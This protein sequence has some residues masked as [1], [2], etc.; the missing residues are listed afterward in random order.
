MRAIIAGGRGFIGHNL[1]QRLLGQGWKVHVIDNL[2]TGSNPKQAGATYDEEN[3]VNVEFMKHRVAEFKPNVIFHE[4]AIPRVSY[5]VKNP[6][7]TTVDNVLGTVS[8]LESVRVYTANCKIIVAS[9]SSVYGDADELPT[10]ETCIPNPC[11][12]YALQKL[13]LEGW[14]HMYANLYGLDICCLRYFNCYDEETD[15]LTY[16][17]FKRFKDITFE[18]KIATLNPVNRNIEYYKPIDIQKHNY[19][20]D[21]VHFEG[22]KIDLFVTPEHQILTTDRDGDTLLFRSAKEL[23]DS[24]EYKS[25]FAQN[26][27]WRG[28]EILNEII[29]EVRNE[30]ENSRLRPENAKKEI[31]MMKWVK[32]LGWFLSEGSAFSGKSSSYGKE[33]KY[34]RITITQKDEKTI[35]EIHKLVSEIGFNSN[36]V[37]HT[38]DCYE[39]Q[40]HSKQLFKHLKIF[41]HNKHIPRHILNLPI[42]YLVLL[43]ETLMRG[44]GTKSKPI[45]TTKY[46]S[47]ASDFQELLLKLGWY[48]RCRK[49]YSERFDCHVYRIY[50]HQRS[51][52][53]FGS[54]GKGIYAS[55]K[56]Y[57]GKVYDVT[58]PNHIIYVRR[59][60]FCC[61][62]GNCFGKH[63]LFGGPYS[64][65]LSAWLYSLFVD[66]SVRPF[67][68]GD[69]TQTRDFCCVDNVVSA[70]LL[71][72]QSSIKFKGHVFNIAQG[73]SHSLIYVKELLEKISGKSLNLEMRAPRKGDVKNTL[74]NIDH[75]RR[76]LGYNPDTNF[77][78]QVEVMANWYKE[79][80]PNANSVA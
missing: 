4:A 13:Q 44:D 39:V 27:S 61:W 51:I 34:C 50:K 1:T 57:M 42:K 69:G 66:Q 49:E 9:S 10:R 36:I 59:N 77:D 3:V 56:H 31:P 25:Y 58:V 40:I 22:K 74:A 79:S 7:Q 8:V 54:K 14:C 28:V 65:V 60:G 5:S 75:A 12:P 45:Y 33:H 46:Q 47:F 48:G 35:Q 63:S 78:N 15:I 73:E 76:I 6:Y 62:S 71:A 29:P 55:K 17:G 23:L 21:M 11:S 16:D 30:E 24:N 70:N 20:G 67:L 43:H 72:A 52:I 37:K 19:D 64:T 2:S 41:Q 38:T 68:E 80:Y 32:F 53:A 26:C 18:D